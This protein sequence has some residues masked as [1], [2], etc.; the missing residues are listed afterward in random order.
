MTILDLLM[1]ITD[2]L[3]LTSTSTCSDVPHSRCQD[4]MVEGIWKSSP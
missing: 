1:Q 4:V 2:W 3:Y